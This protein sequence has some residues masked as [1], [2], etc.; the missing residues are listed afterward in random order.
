VLP[1]VYRTLV[2]ESGWTAEKYEIWL[3]D[4]TVRGLLGGP[5]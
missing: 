1:E 3:G 2:V 5:A 4:S